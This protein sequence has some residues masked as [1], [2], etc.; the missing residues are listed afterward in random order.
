[1]HRKRR[2]IEWSSRNR[3]TF[4]NHFSSM[5]S[6]VPIS[7]IKTNQKFY[8]SF[9]L[10]Y[11]GKMVID[12]STFSQLKIIEKFRSVFLITNKFQ[13]K[14][15]CSFC[16]RIEQ[17]NSEKKENTETEKNNVRQERTETKRERKTFSR[18]QNL[19]KQNSLLR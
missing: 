11:Q 3:L 19:E 10:Y 12:R 8:R 6:K 4:N 14:I 1:M 16:F 5:I 2:L 18:A 15:R 7:L 17:K 9:L 13:K